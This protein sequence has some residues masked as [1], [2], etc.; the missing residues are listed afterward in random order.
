MNTEPEKKI[1]EM[2]E[3]RKNE[4]A[5]ETKELVKK[6]NVDA[7]ANILIRMQ[8]ENYALRSEFVNLKQMISKVTQ[9]KIELQTQLN[10]LKA[11]GGRGIMGGTGST[12]HTS[13]E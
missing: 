1:K 12:V 5:S 11:M 2:E 13:D 3:K 8:N 9:D 6:M 4:E 7:V 10:I